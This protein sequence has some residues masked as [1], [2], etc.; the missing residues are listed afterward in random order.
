[1]TSDD[2][3]KPLSR[4]FSHSRLS[5]QLLSS[6]RIV[7]AA[8]TCQ[9][10]G[11]RD[12]EM[13]LP[14]NGLAANTVPFGAVT[15]PVNNVPLAVLVSVRVRYNA[16]TEGVRKIPAAG[17]AK[18]YDPPKAMLKSGV[19]TGVAIS[20]LALMMPAAQSGALFAPLGPSGTR[21]AASCAWQSRCCCRTALTP[22]W[23][24][25]SV[26]LTLYLSF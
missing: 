20:P 12:P 18:S 16:L 10:A 11:V 22:Y 2:C 13:M 4:Q 15:L 26:S 21:R 24:G 19:R 8:A 1:M 25:L 5:V 14:P 23:L 6:V 3:E 17:M 9:N 7:S